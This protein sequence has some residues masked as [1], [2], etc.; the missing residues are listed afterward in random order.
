MEVE[1][2]LHYFSVSAIPFTRSR[3]L[4]IKG[5]MGQVLFIHLVYMT[6]YNIWKCY[7][8]IFLNF[9]SKL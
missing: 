1:R 6:K 7:R 8:E 2:V 3:Q 5:K 4:L 9:L